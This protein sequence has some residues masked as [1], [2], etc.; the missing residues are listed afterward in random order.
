MITRILSTV[1]IISFLNIKSSFCQHSGMEKANEQ[2]MLQ[3]KISDSYVRFSNHNRSFKPA[4]RNVFTGSSGTTITTIQV[5]TVEGGFD[6]QQD[7]ANEPSIA[8]NPSNPNL[9]AIGWRQ[10]DYIGNNFRQAGWN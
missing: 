10:F 6:L 3:E 2:L 1:A 5:N 9:I 8:V 4:Y 7:A